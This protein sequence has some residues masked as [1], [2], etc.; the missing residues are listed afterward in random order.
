MGKRPHKT[1]QGDS[2]TAV[3]VA[4]KEHRMTEGS[5]GGTRPSSE[6]GGVRQRA[7]KGG[8]FDVYKSG[9]G[10]HT[11]VGTG[12]VSG[13]LVCW[14]AYAL[15]EKLYMLDHRWLQVFIPVGVIIAIG[16]FGYWILALNRK[17]CDFLI[18]TEGEMKKVN[19]TSRAEII[20]STKVVIFM[21]VSMSSMLF[22]VDLFFMTI[23]G[24]AGVLKGTTVVDVLRESF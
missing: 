9:Q 2:G 7:G 17:V 11:R 20:G 8:F 23:F 18:A 4:E 14:G 21:V 12:F 24:W 3:A 15:Y 22:I 19:W 1:S 10:Y 13:A 6:S 5:A 16:L